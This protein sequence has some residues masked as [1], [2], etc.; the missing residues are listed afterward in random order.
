M[1]PFGDGRQESWEPSP[2]ATLDEISA[3]RC[4]VLLNEPNT[5]ISP[6]PAPDGSFSV[7]RA[8]NT[9]EK[10]T[11]GSHSSINHPGSAEESNTRCNSTFW[12]D[13]NTANA[14]LSAPQGI[15]MLA[16]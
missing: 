4:S 8:P 3:A 5:I 10:S 12:S 11:K 14:V 16:I 1:V 9:V 6:S 15:G 13:A 7:P 2:E